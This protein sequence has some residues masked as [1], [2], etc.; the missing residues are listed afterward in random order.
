MLGQQER[1]IKEQGQT[2]KEREPRSKRVH[3]RNIEMKSQGNRSPWAGEI[4]GRMTM[5][6]GVRM[7]SGTC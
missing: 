5:L 1:K 2:D 6:R 4:E 7:P 3:G